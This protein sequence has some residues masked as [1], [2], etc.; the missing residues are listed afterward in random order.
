M[1]RMKRFSTN[2]RR[3]SGF[4]FGNGGFR[5]RSGY[6][7]KPISATFTTHFRWARKPCMYLSTFSATS[8]GASR[9]GSTTTSASAASALNAGRGRKRRPGLALSDGRGAAASMGAA[10]LMPR[11]YD[12]AST[13]RKPPPAGGAQT[14]TPYA[15]VKASWAYASDA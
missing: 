3:A 11:L 10:I 13:D 9:P 14:D 15:S 1:S 5:K 4:I 2:S 8:P 12:P 7:H 6:S